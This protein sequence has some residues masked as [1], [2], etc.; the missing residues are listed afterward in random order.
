MAP[1][2]GLLRGDLPDQCRNA[3]PDVQPGALDG[4]SRPAR[5]AEAEVCCQLSDEPADLGF[6]AG[7]AAVVA[8]GACLSK[9]LPEICETACLEEVAGRLLGQLP[10]TPRRRHEVD[11]QELTPRVCHEL[12]EIA[13]PL[14]VPDSQDP[15]AEHDHPVV[16]F[17]TQQVVRG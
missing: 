15:T 17:P 1:Q 10:N 7:G 4:R 13:Y 5:G 2:D 9:R 8:K 12:R 16:A 6:G 11:G 14:G 3:L